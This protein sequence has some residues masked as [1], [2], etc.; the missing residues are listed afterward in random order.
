MELHK[1]KQ[2]KIAYT[3]ANGEKTERIIIPTTD[4][5]TFV[6][7]HDVTGLDPIEVDYLITKRK[8]YAAYVATFMQS[9]FDFATWCEHTT[10][11]PINEKLEKYRTFTVENITLL[12]EY[13]TSIKKLDDK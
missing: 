4:T 13:I 5:T 7:A 1:N 2:Y 11:S 8:E 6:R 10:A 9:I 3:K 12:E